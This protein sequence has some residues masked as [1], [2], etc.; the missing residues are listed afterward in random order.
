MEFKTIGLF[1]HM[2]SQD[3][4]ETVAVICSFLR[5]KRCRIV[6][7][8]SLAESLNSDDTEVANIH[9]MGSMIDLA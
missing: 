5:D 6:L 1:G 7:E 8:S 9:T 2:R 4:R 3:I